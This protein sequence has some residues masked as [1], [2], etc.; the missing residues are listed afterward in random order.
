MDNMLLYMSTIW[1][2]YL[3]VE[4][5]C[6]SSMIN[7]YHSAFKLCFQLCPLP[8]FL[9]SSSPELTVCQTCLALLPDS[10]CFLYLEVPS[11]PTVSFLLQKSSPANTKQVIS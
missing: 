11:L 8:M 3:N 5:P 7:T 9:T 4:M 10:G 1:R 2:S 6:V